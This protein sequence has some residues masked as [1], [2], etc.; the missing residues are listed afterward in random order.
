[1]RVL[2]KWCLR[3][4]VAETSQLSGITVVV[5]EKE[6]RPGLCKP[7]LLLAVPSDLPLFYLGTG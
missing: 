1:M 6:G 4:S 7:G 3:V 5:S 2:G